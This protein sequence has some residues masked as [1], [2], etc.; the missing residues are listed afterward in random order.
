MPDAHAPE[1]AETSPTPRDR[2]IDA[3]TGLFCK[4][5]IN[6]TGID[7]IVD[8]AGTAK[9]TLY[10]HFK[11]KPDLVEAVLDAEGKAWRD[12]FLAAIDRAETPR[13][14]LE[15][16]FPVLKSWFGEPGYAGCAL[17]NAVG[18]HARDEARLRDVANRHKSIVINHI[19]GLAS[20]AGAAGPDLLARQI[21]LLMD[22]AIVA[23]MVTR[24][25]GV[26]DAAGLAARALLDQACG[27]PK[28]RRAR[29]AGLQG[30]AAAL[31]KEDLSVVD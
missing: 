2:L 23:A 21:G 29:R 13:G 1:N 11:A 20:A 22:G 8:A 30:G 27:P 16:I 5:G 25:P 18:E 4:N 19:A 26:A 7:A 14:R 15:S 12:R 17:T 24:D 28:I 3:A 9:T 31:A 6:A 10:K